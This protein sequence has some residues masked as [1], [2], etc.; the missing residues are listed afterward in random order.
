MTPFSKWSAKW[1]L[2]PRPPSCSTI[3]VSD[4]SWVVTSPRAPASTRPRTT[5]SAPSRRSWELV[6]QP[7]ALVTRAAVE[8]FGEGVVGVLERIRGQRA[9]G[10]EL[11]DGGQPAGDGLARN[12]PPGLDGVGHLRAPQEQVGQR[13]EELVAPRV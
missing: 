1:T 11:A 2:A 6:P 12:R 4:R 3:C 5:A 7:F 10:L 9:Q 8:H 13:G